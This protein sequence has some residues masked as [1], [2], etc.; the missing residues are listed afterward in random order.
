MRAASRAI[1]RRKHGLRERA[2]IS[3]LKGDDISALISEIEAELRHS[4]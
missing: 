4:G 3:P 1:R 2:S